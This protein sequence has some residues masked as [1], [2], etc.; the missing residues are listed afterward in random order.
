[1]E[2]LE[3]QFLSNK[4]PSWSGNYINFQSGWGMIYSVTHYL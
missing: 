3:Q 4:A 1:M 2:E